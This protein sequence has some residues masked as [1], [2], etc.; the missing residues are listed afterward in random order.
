MAAHRPRKCGNVRP[1]N[2]RPRSHDAHPGYGSTGHA[3]LPVVS[4]DRL[5]RSPVPAPATWH[6][7][8]L[9]RAAAADVGALPR[10]PKHGVD[11]RP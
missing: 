3:V 11:C 10:S 4:G 9:E 2:L 1:T 6:L 5:T 7:I 8:D